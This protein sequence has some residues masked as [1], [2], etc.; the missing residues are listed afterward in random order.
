MDLWQQ[1]QETAGSHLADQGKEGVFVLSWLLLS[2][3]VFICDFSSLPLCIH[4]WLLLSLP[5]YSFVGPQPAG[6]VFLDP[7]QA[8]WSSTN[9]LQKH[10]E[11][12]AQ[13]CAP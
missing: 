10:P 6:R 3:F 9:P 12:S 7:G 13:R 8:F 5:L 4:L 2:P 11:R 1:E